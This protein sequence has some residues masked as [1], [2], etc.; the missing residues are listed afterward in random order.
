M[1][2]QVVFEDDVHATLHLNEPRQFKRLQNLF[3]YFEAPIFH[4]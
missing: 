4:I 1:P 3:P 2:L